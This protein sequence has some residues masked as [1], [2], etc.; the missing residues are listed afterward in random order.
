MGIRTKLCP[1]GGGNTESDVWCNV[2]TVPSSAS[3][4]L[5][6]NGVNYATKNLKVEKGSTVSYYIN[7]S[8]N[9]YNSS[10]SWI[11]NE[12]TTKSVALDPWPYKA[13]QLV[14]SGTSNFSFKPQMTGYYKVNLYV[15]P[16]PYHYY[17]TNTYWTQAYYLRNSDGSYYKESYINAWINTVNMPYNYGGWVEFNVNLSSSYTYN[18][19]SVATVYNFSNY[20]TKN[21]RYT[22]ESAYRGNGLVNISSSVAAGV[23]GSSIGDEAESSVRFSGGTSPY[24]VSTSAR[25]TFGLQRKDAQINTNTTN[26]QKII[27]NSGIASTI[28]NFGYWNFYNTS[29]ISNG[30]FTS[31]QSGGGTKI[32]FIKPRS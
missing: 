15:S 32:Y 12:S 14:T 13:G 7:I 1:M 3:C 11:I 23:V 16:H 30:L 26:A 24:N 18:F 6:Y 22:S 10:G 29:K 17:N 4:V 21:P 8:Q 28:S 27:V 19:N 2:T 20:T 5:V 25:V 31:Y 9:Y